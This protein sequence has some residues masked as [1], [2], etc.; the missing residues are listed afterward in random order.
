MLD[1]HNLKPDRRAAV[2]L[3]LDILN[4]EDM[5]EVQG[6]MLVAL[7][8]LLCLIR[9]PN[10]VILWSTGTHPAFPSCAFLGSTCSCMRSLPIQ[11]HRATR[12]PPFSGGPGPQMVNSSL[13]LLPDATRPY[14]SYYGPTT[15]ALHTHTHLDIPAIT[16]AC[17]LCLHTRGVTNPRITLS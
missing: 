5:T 4:H 17:M 10:S 12:P 14:T 15:C 2:E 8:T 6:P 9:D 1:L 16:H 13:Q 11:T 3:M 7:S